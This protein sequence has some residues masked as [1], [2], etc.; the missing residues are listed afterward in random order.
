MP[1]TIT[2]N[3]YVAYSDNDDKMSISNCPQTQTRN[4]RRDGGDNA[5]L[6]SQPQISQ[7]KRKSEKNSIID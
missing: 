4:K 6:I 1:Q 2:V 3:R 7:E 5:N